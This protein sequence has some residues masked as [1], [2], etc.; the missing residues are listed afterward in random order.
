MGKKSASDVSSEPTMIVGKAAQ[1]PAPESR[2]DLSGPS[3]LPPPP[4]SPPPGEPPAPGLSDRNKTLIVVGSIV[5]FLCC[6]CLA[7]IV[8][9]S[10][11][12]SGQPSVVPVPQTMLPLLLPL[13]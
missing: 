5:L 1:P 12:P 2:P 8:V 6:G 13:M 4:A 10:L 9:T 11:M 7:L 3:T